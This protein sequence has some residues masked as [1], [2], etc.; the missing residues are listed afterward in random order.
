MIWIPRQCY[1]DMVDLV[2]EIIQH[3]N[4][5]DGYYWIDDKA[6]NLL[7]ILKQDI[8]SVNPDIFEQ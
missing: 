5:E 7:A 2:K 3:A 6:N 8:P 4:Y 1:D